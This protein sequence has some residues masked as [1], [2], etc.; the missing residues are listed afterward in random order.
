MK[1]AT[2]EFIHGTPETTA[3]TIMPLDMSI[4]GIIAR[5]TE[6][7]PSVRPGM[8]TMPRRKIA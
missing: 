7:P 8:V 5:R 1:I 6:A 2:S 4:E 3:T